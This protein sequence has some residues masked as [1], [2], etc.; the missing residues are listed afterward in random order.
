MVT[1]QNIVLACWAAILLYWIISARS[2]KPAQEIKR[3]FGSLWVNA[4]RLILTFLFIEGFGL[5]MPVYPFALLFAPHSQSILIV[6]VVMVA[7]GLVVA[8]LARRTLASNWSKDIDL[9]M[10]HELITTGIYSSVRH[11]IYTGILLMA[12]GTLLFKGTIG[13]LI[14]FLIILT[15]MMFK[16]KEEEELLMKHFPEEYPAYKKRVKA[17]IPF[18]W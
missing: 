12:L 11:P 4:G 13:L 3:H 18:I 15:F 7:V 10:S 16:I 2:A 8:V 14:F 5:L 17:L 9:K 6:G 1:L